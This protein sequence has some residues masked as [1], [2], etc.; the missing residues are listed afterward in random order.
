MKEN[1]FENEVRHLALD[2][3]IRAL[4]EA[5]LKSP[6]ITDKVVEGVVTRFRKYVSGLFRGGN[7]AIIARHVDWY[8]YFPTTG[9]LLSTA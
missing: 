3:I 6:G 2:G 5:E 1:R 9:F 4:E 8:F 7:W